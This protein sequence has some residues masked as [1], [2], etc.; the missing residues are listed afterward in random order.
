MREDFSEALEIYA[1][2]AGVPVDRVL[3]EIS[4]ALVMAYKKITKSENVEVQV[5][6][7]SS[8]LKLFSK[9]I[10]KEA[11]QD[12]INEISLEEAQKNKKD[13][14]I[15]EEILI[16]INPE[17]MGR[18][19][20]QISQQVIIE[21]ISKI[22]N[23]M[24]YEEYKAKIGQVTAGVFQRRIKRDD[25][26]VDLN[27]IECIL[28]AEKQLPKDRIKI[29]EKV[30]VYIKNVEQGK[31]SVK[32]ILSRT[33]PEFVKKL[34]EIEV[35]EIASGI[36]KIK[37]IAREPGERSKI[38][39]Y[40]QES[41]IDPVGAC[42][43]MKGV[44]IQSIIRELDGE[45]IDII[46][47]DNEIERYLNNLLSP[48][49]VLNIKLNYNEKIAIVVVPSDQLSAAIGRDGKN[50]RLSAILLGW[51]IDIKSETDF[52]KLLQAE[53]SR[54]M[55][56]ELFQEPPSKLKKEKKTEKKTKKVTTPI[57]ETKAMEEDTSEEISIDELPEVSAMV[58]KKL[59]EAN[60]NTIESILNLSRDEFMK[61]PGIS[62][63]S[64]EL[65]IHSLKENVK[66]V[67]E[68]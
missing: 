6:K 53:E 39:V 11:V 19:A 10:V 1:T 21:N 36:V 52:E 9:K 13:S 24:L 35:P 25:I 60:F 63:K 26:I 16:E 47:W 27:K 54:K 8:A 23:D 68:E 62:K 59:K 48:I 66:V 58:I 15:G 2:K 64:A 32:V 3:E 37:G 45:K 43:G 61:I 50:V 4:K 44:R 42:V 22:K 5:D 51:T 12:R 30:R 38:A 56:K 7:N 46:R 41:D 20:A 18:I 31:N 40:S 67:E 49:K 33:D 17:D 65:I 34:F 55:L 28:P 14:Q 29:G 57:E